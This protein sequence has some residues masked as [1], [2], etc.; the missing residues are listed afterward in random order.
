VLSDKVCHLCGKFVV[1]GTDPPKELLGRT[2]GYWEYSNF[3]SEP[4]ACIGGEQ[5]TRH[6][7]IIIEAGNEQGQK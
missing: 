4:R 3:K 5:I 6:N 1:R 7:I 2:S